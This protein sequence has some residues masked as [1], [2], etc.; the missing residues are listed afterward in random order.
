M[1]FGLTMRCAWVYFFYSHSECAL[2]EMIGRLQ[3]AVVQISRVLNGGGLL[4]N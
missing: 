3:A 4:W 1:G 2:H